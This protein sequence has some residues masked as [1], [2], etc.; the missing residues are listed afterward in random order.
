MNG[1]RS[2]EMRVDET[3]R[4]DLSSSIYRLSA[5]K[6]LGAYCSNASVT[7]TE[8]SDAVCACARIHD[9]P[10]SDNNIEIRLSGK[11]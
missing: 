6:H 9:S 10:V 4:H 7:H 8:V 11:G 3:G 5:N 2:M 1:Q